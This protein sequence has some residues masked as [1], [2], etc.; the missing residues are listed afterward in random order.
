MI[1]VRFFHLLRQRQEDVISSLVEELVYSKTNV[2]LKMCDERAVEHLSEYL[3]SHRPES[4][5]PHGF[6][7]DVFVKEQPVWITHQDE[8]PNNAVVMIAGLGARAYLENNIRLCYELLDGN[9]PDAVHMARVNWK[10]YKE[11][12]WLVTYWQTDEAG[13][14]ARKA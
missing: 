13:I 7:K 14:W 11:R 8:N 2:L 4:F 12:G 1:E 6:G 5:L 3:W 10:S 9:N